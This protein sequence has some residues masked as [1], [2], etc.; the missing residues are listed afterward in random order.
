[1]RMT[2]EGIATG[3][4]GVP[5]CYE[6]GLQKAVPLVLKKEILGSEKIGCESERQ[7]AQGA[8]KIMQRK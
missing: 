2:V 5:V 8:C 3:V 6:F 7:S 4:K 1:M